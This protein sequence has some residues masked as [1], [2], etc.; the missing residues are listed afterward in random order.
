MT[1][2]L[3]TLL[4]A[5]RLR[6][7][8]PALAALAATVPAIGL[9]T[10]PAEAATSATLAFHCTYP[11]IGSQPMALK[12]ST[13]LPSSIKTGESTGPIQIEALASQNAETTKGLTAVGAAK[14]G[15]SADAKAHID[16]PGSNGLD[17]SVPV[18][19]ADAAIPTSGGFEV[20]ATAGIAP[21]S[22]AQAGTARVT[23]NRMVLTITPRVADGRTTGLDT[24]DVDCTLDDGQDGVVATIDVTG[25][26]TPPPPPPP[27]SLTYGISG[28]SLL[29]APQAQVPLQGTAKVDLTG[30][31]V[32]AALALQPTH[33]AFSLFGFL[34]A[35]ADV[36]LTP[37]G[38]TTGQIGTG[39][40]TTETKV[41]VTLPSIT[42]FGFPVGGGP[43]CRTT[44]PAAVPL[45]ATTFDPARGGVLRGTYTLPTF[46]GCGIA[47]YAV[48]AA[49][50][51][52]GN[53]IAVTLTRS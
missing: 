12:V 3:T 26:T 14:L 1:S 34:P 5:R 16:V 18:T 9:A 2:T 44:A 33:T 27:T 50:S 39:G 30:T 24:F 53:T 48:N 37:A 32:S 4:R 23:L 43:D 13:S 41:G 49:V 38:P 25:G 28:S 6:A 20:K 17:L 45:S 11:L 10:A 46:S 40:V 51:G 42:A 15:G 22:F 35:A 31:A 36:V 21:I 47:T 19:L 52:P 29:K 7:T 8:V